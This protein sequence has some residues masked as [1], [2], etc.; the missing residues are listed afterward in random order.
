VNE[1]TLDDQTV[2]VS[3]EQMVHGY[4]PFQRTTVA[5]LIAM[6]RRLSA[7]EHPLGE[8]FYHGFVSGRLGEYRC[9]KCNTILYLPN[10][11]SREWSAARA[12][13]KGQSE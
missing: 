2:L 8:L 10:L 9:N 6:V 13:L 12:E 3:A 5:A 11:D 4:I 7:C 1:Q